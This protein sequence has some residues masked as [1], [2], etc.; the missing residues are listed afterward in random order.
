MSPPNPM[1]LVES[2]L[3]EG[4]YPPASFYFKVVLSATLGLRDTSF[5]EVSGIVSELST[6]EY[7]EGGEN[8]YKHNLQAYCGALKE[9]CGARGINYMFTDTKV[10]FDHIVLSYFRRR[11]LIK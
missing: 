9:Y 2:L 1:S 11:G 5:Q 7:A 6:E 8:R 3:G 10:P 4:T